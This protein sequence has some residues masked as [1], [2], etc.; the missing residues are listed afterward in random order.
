MSAPKINIGVV[1]AGNPNHAK[2]AIR[3]CA[4]KRIEN[5]FGV[6]KK[7]MFYSLQVGEPAQAIQF[8]AEVGRYIEDLG[9]MLTNFSI[10]AS[11]IEKLDLVI[12]VDTSVAH[13]AGAL[14]K[15]VWTLL[16]YSPD[17]RWMMDRA[18]SP[19]YPTMRLFRQPKSGDWDT[20]F[21]EVKKALKN[22]K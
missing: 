19:W 7:A 18:D 5:L 20:V 15:P 3:S 8:S 13:L 9:D 17:W 14:G 12:T 1:W 21:A 16:Q 11:V 6:N 4:F 22:C 10:T 2:D